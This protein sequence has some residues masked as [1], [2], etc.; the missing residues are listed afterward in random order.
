MAINQIEGLLESLAPPRCIVGLGSAPGPDT[1]PAYL[2]MRDGLTQCLGGQIA[3][4]AETLQHA[5]I[6]YRKAG[7]KRSASLAQKAVG[8]CFDAITDC[9]AART[10][11][12]KSIRMLKEAGI[13]DEAARVQIL[14]ARFEAGHGEK[15]EAMNAL[16]AALVIYREIV[17]PVGQIEALCQYA[18]LA[19][20]GGERSE[21]HERA[22]E[23]LTLIERVDDVNTHEKLRARA[24][25]L[26]AA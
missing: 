17:H 10:A 6:L 12:C 13:H 14:M 8:L 21:A 5:Y 1:R 4:A 3:L 2:A 11:Y 18:E 22:R 26:L 15:R 19:L 7:D 23:A 9:A 25:T 24:E 20:A 16:R